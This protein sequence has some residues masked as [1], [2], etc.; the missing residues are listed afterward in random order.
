MK[1]RGVSSDCSSKVPTVNV[2]PRQAGLVSTPEQIFTLETL[3]SR[4]KTRNVSIPV[5]GRY[6]AHILG[7]SNILRY[8]AS[9]PLHGN[10]KLN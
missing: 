4:K 6:C 9:I 7:L 2:L 8:H 3:P 10:I 1:H 5:L